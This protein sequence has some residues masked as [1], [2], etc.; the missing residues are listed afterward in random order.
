L[1]ASVALY[2]KIAKGE[3]EVKKIIKNAARMTPIFLALAMF[4][5][6]PTDKDVKW[7]TSVDFPLTANKKFYLGAQMDTL[8]FNHKQVQTTTSYSYDTIK[9]A[10]KPDSIVT[11]KTIDTT[12]E[13]LKAYP[14]YDSIEKKLKVDTVAFGFPIDTVTSYSISEDSMKDKTFDDGFG[15]IPLSGAPAT[16]MSISLPA[17]TYPGGTA[18]PVPSSQLKLKWVYH[19][20]LR[21]TAQF[22]NVTLT[23][24]SSAN[25]SQVSLTLGTLGTAIIANLNANSSATAQYSAQAK[26][27]DSII[28]VTASFT[29]SGLTTITAGSNIS[30]SLSLN[31][32]YANKVVVLDSMLAGYQ[33]TFT[34]NYK[35]TDTVDVSYIDID[36]GFFTYFV[37]NR[38]SVQMQ[39]SVTHRNLWVSDWCQ[40]TNII[41]GKDLVGLT[42]ADSEN[43]YG[44]E[45]TPHTARVDFPPG[46]VS[47]F[48]KTN[49]S[50]ERMF[51]DWDTSYEWDT[52]ANKLDTNYNSVSKVDYRINVQV[53]DKPVTLNANDSLHFIIRSR[54]FKF[55]DMYGRSMEEYTRTSDTSKIP[56]KLPWSQAVTDS[57]RNHFV[58]QKVLANVRTRFNIPAGAFIDTV[59]VTYDISS[60]HDPTK[61]RDSTIIVTHVMRDSVYLRSIDITKVVNDYPDTVKVKVTLTVPKHTP[62]KAVNDLT[63]ALD[64]DYPKYIGRMTVHGEVKYDMVAPLSWFVRDTTIMDLGGTKVDMGGASGALKTFAIMS[65]KTA[66]LNIK[67]TNFTNVYL[68]LYAL[69]A[70]DPARVDSLVDTSDAVHYIKTNKFTDLINHPKPGYVNLLGNTGLLIPPRNKSASNSIVLTEQDLNQIL[71]ADTIGMRWEV[72][73]IPNSNAAGVIDTSFDALLNTDWLILNSWIHIDGVNSLDSLFKKR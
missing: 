45:V 27:I 47:Q 40:R 69:L 43:Y 23:N 44:G 7:R 16:V 14:W 26:I 1:R 20:E 6:S 59:R 33:R 32:L 61:K 13:I 11:I 34:N 31:N 54:S 41:S 71:N 73:F 49:I 21:D 35:L 42:T 57:L 15:P 67:V 3:C 68:R 66:S 60:I 24:N 63:D 56:V 2:A 36:K 65:D 46:Q 28:T 29:P 19:L 8:F 18:V 53:N 25:F 22:V 58:L 48:S 5:S 51:P 10:G 62:L 38:T 4:C 39:I 70:T 50:G 72:R 9:R 37:T 17:G 30:A 55:S 52:L 12:M 64:P